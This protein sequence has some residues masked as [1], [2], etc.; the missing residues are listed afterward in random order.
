[1]LGLQLKRLLPDGLSEF[2]Q[3]MDGSAYAFTKL[4][5]GNKGVTAIT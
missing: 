3:I 2:R 4:N 1:M 5:L